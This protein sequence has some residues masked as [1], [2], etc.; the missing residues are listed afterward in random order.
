MSSTSTSPPIASTNPRATARPRPT[1]SPDGRSPNRWNGSNTR[2]RSSSG[3]PGP[4]STIRSSTR[5]PAS[6]PRMRTGPS[7][8][9][10]DRALDAMFAIARSRSAASTSTRGSV[11][12]TSTSMPRPWSL[13][14]ASAFGTTSSSPTTWWTRRRLPVWILLASSRLP[15]RELSR[16]VSSSIVARNSATSSAFH[17]TSSWRRLL[18]AALT[19]ASGVRRSWE[20]AARIAARRSLTSTS[21]AASSA[22]RFSARART[23]TASCATNAASTRRLSAGNRGPRITSDVSSPRSSVSVPSSGVD[24]APTPA[25]ASTSQLPSSVSR[26]TDTASKPNVVRTCWTRP[27]S[28]SSSATSQPARCARAS[29]SARPRCASARRRA[30][31][32]TSPL[33]TA[34]TATNTKIANRCSGSAIVHVWIGG[35]K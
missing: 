8:P 35:T 17:V 25:S 15:T 16:S 10:Y 2:W 11:S 22:S 29:A 1:P 6:D 24:G 14:L 19:D 32:L 27:G 23:A 34:A 28:G 5:P 18:T 9:P 3:M 13:M 21:S 7:E 20:T 31:R 26:R 4:R 30:A 12:G 33:T